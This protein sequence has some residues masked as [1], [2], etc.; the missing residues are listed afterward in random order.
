MFLDEGHYLSLEENI[1]AFINESRERMDAQ[2]IRMSIMKTNMETKFTNL[3]VILKTLENQ[4]SQLALKMSEIPSRPLP[5]DIEDM[6][7]CDFMNLSSKE[8]LLG[9][10]LVE[11]DENELAIEKDH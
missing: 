6:W 1:N 5:C 2:D 8:E 7:E 10:T 3:D 9:P 4:T 11:E